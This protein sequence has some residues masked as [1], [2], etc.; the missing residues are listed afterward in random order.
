MDGYYFPGTFGFIWA[1]LSFGFWEAENWETAS[2]FGVATWLGDLGLATPLIF[3]GSESDYFF[4]YFFFSFYSNSVPNILKTSFVF[5]RY[6]RR[7]SVIK[8]KV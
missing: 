3:A 4:I 6:W 7:V 1:V 5:D 8:E 2:V